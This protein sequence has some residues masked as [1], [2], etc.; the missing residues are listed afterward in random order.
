MRKIILAIV[1]ALL[2]YLVYY[3]IFENNYNNWPIVNAKP[4]G[5]TI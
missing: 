4:Q 3:V 2:V 1:L 5:E